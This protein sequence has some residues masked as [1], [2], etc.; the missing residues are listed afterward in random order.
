MKEGSAANNFGYALI[1]WATLGFLH[2]GHWWVFPCLASEQ[3]AG[4]EWLCRWHAV[5]YIMGIFVTAAGGGY[6]QSGTARQCPGGED[7]SPNCL[8][9]EQT[10]AYQIIY[11]LHYIGL[12]WNFAHWIMDGFHLWSWSKQLARAQQMRLLA[13]DA[14]LRWLYSCILWFAVVLATLTWT[15]LFQW[16]T[17]NAEQPS[18]LNTLAGILLMEFIVVLLVSC[19]AVRARHLLAVQ[20]VSA[21]A[22]KQ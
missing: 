21:G 15:V 6:C 19:L 5:S 4:Q 8:F 18:T 13:T 20:T 7:M 12:A 22:E 16:T 9:T 14:S 10:L 3:D 2:G 1:A 11:I 17:G